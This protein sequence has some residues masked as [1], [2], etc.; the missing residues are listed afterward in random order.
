[1]NRYIMTS[2]IAPFISK[3][4]D[5]IQNAPNELIEWTTDGSGFVVKDP[6]RLEK[7]VL[8][9]YFK[10][11]NFSSFARQLGFYGFRKSTKFVWTDSSSIAT[12]CCE[13][14]HKNFLRGRLDLM[15]DIQRKTY[16]LNE[17]EDEIKDKIEMLASRVDQLNNLVQKLLD[18]KLVADSPVYTHP[19]EFDVSFALSHDDML[20]LFGTIASK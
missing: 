19:V 18:E 7:E 6:K 11:N 1:M 17:E 16:G 9:K 14:R 13:Y 20:E 10:H 5:L 8:H 4:H 12:R 2:S 15:T 3:T